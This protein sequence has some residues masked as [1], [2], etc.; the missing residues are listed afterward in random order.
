MVDCINAMVVLSSEDLIGRIYIVQ[1]F[2]FLMQSVLV[3]I[4][5][6]SPSVCRTNPF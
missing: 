1:P 6:L 3:S 5:Q 4:R 2:I